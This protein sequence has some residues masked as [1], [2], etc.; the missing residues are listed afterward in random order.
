MGIILSVERI[1]NFVERRGY[2]SSHEEFAED[3]E[4]NAKKRITNV[5]HELG[6]WSL[7]RHNVNRS[8]PPARHDTL[9]GL[10][11]LVIKV[12]SVIAPNPTYL[13]INL[14]ECQRRCLSI[15]ASIHHQY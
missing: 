15:G 9:Q 1:E 8:R 4:V 5:L 13:T 11:V 12:S 6:I 2:A 7:Q 10:T 3:Y 14:N